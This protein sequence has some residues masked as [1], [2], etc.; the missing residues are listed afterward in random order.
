MDQ[1]AIKPV[2]DAEERVAKAHGAAHDGVE[3]RLGV[4]RRARDHPQDLARRGLLFKRLGQLRLKPSA[5]PGLALGRLC[6]RLF[7]LLS[8]GP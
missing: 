5:L 6:Q 8:C 2:S 3:D 7:E 4:S 1:L